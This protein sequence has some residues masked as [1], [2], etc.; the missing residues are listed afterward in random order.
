MLLLNFNFYSF[1]RKYVFDITCITY[2]FILYLLYI[3][4]HFDIL[5]VIVK[6]M[7]EMGESWTD[8]RNERLL[9]F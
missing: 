9:H 7:R 8:G 5:H 6:I 2:F 3:L 4:Y 1:E